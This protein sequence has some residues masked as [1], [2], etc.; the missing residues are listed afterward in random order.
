MGLKP[1]NKKTKKNTKVKDPFRLLVLRTD[2]FKDV[3]EALESKHVAPVG[4]VVH[5]LVVPEAFE[6]AVGKVYH[7]HVDAWGRGRVQGQRRL[8]PGGDF[9]LGGCLGPLG[10]PAF[11][12]DEQRAGVEAV[13][14]LT[15]EHGFEAAQLAQDGL[16]K[17]PAQ[18][19]TVVHEL[20]ERV[21]ETLNRQTSAVVLV[22]AQVVARV[23]LVHL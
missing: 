21:A 1:K 16:E 4:P 2:R 7:A 13:G 22:A 8:A 23:H 12:D 20:V 6:G 3:D 14:G 17:V 19:G 15:L 11:V 5:R 10:F 18:L 9:L